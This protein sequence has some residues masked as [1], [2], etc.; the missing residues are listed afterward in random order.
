MNDA[1]E[2]GYMTVEAALVLPVVLCAMVV[3]IYLGFF[4]Y[5]RCAM[6]QDAYLHAQQEAVARGRTGWKEDSLRHVCRT[7][8]LAEERT[9]QVQKGASV[10]CSVTAQL[11]TGVFSGSALMPDDWRLCAVERARTTDPPRSFRRYRRIRA[12]LAAAASEKGE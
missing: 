7:I 3:L 4:L 10:T 9:E 5:D 12:V 11:V 1:R 6:E 2:G 8:L